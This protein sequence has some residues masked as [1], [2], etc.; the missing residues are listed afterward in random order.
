MWVFSGVIEMVYSAFKWKTGAP[1]GTV[2]NIGSRTRSREKQKSLYWASISPFFNLT[3]Y[4]VYAESDN[5]K[6]AISRAANDMGKN[7][8]VCIL[9]RETEMW[10]LHILSSRAAD[11]A[12][13]TDMC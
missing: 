12:N 6:H 11:T 8:P 1:M 10:L 9:L 13:F 5:N 2:L 4:E 7:P 3:N